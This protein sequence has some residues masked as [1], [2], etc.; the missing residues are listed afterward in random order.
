MEFSTPYISQ[1]IGVAKRMNCTLLAIMRA[2]IF[3]SGLPR[4]FWPYAAPAAA[5]IRNQTVI[6]GKISK[7]LYKLWISK[8]LNLSN[9]RIWGYKCWIHLPKEKDKLNP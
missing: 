8:R 3:D 5:Y 4:S 1:Q 7:I 9:I 6:V 2:L